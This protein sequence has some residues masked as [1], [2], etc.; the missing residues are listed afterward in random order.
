MPANNAEIPILKELTRNHSAGIRSFPEDN[1]MAYGFH[2][3]HASITEALEASVP[4]EESER[5]V[6]L[7]VDD[8][9]LIVE[10]L[11][12]IL[13]HAG[14]AVMKAYDGASALDI[15]RT[16]PPDLLISDVAM[17]GMDGITLAVAVSCAV[18]DCGVL[19]F[20]GHAQPRD[21]EDARRAGYDFPLLTKPVHPRTILEHASFCLK[22]RKHS[23]QPQITAARVQLAS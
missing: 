9:E 7:L 5:P 21:L 6:V 8:E 12:A 23:L 18:P 11:A 17:P 2:F 22:S 14:F 19:L 13:T 15:A 1:T 10:T 4:H 16:V 3:A 20:S